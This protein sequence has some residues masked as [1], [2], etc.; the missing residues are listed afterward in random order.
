M[1]SSEVLD[2]W[3]IVDSHS[4]ESR[5]TLRRPPR[6]T[7]GTYDLATPWPRPFVFGPTK[8]VLRARGVLPA[9][10]SVGA[11]RRAGGRRTQRSGS[12]IF[13]ASSSE[14]K[15]AKDVGH[16]GRVAAYVQPLGD[17]I[18]ILCT[19][20]MATTTSAVMA[21]DYRGWLTKYSTSLADQ[22]RRPIYR[23][24]LVTPSA[25]RWHQDPVLVRRSI[26]IV[27]VGTLAVFGPDAGG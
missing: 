14:R 21:F 10:Q 23:F 16:A 22:Y 7:V 19:L 4:F 17:A 5:R 6:N 25:R 20:M 11:V 1:W 18:G 26:R 3:P 27:A 24:L 13:R 9:E 8:L 12:G 2:N 15:T